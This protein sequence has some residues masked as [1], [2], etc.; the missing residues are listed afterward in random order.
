MM[1]KPGS[2]DELMFHRINARNWL[3]GD[4]AFMSWKPS[5]SSVNRGTQS[6]LRDALHTE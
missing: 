5:P 3:S 1:L 6:P 2:F 4:Q